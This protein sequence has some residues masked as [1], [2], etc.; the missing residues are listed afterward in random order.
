MDYII[1]NQQTLPAAEARLPTADRGFRFGDSLF[2]TIAVHGGK[3]CQIAWHLDRLARGLAA[4]KIR[5]DAAPLDNLCRSLI[6]KN[7]V[8]EGLLRIQISRGAGGRGYLPDP[9]AAPTVLIETAPMPD[10]PREPVA[11]WLSSYEKISPRALPVN[12]K[13]GQGNSTLA[14]I[15]AAE[16]HCADALLL[17]HAGHIAETSSGNIFWV[18]DSLL[19]TPKLSCGALDGSIRAALMRL[20]QVREVEGTIETLKNAEAVFITNA[21]WKTLPVGML[22][23]NGYAWD[24]AATAQRFHDIILSG[25]K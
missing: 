9:N 23:P 7:N 3:P 24:S 14:R 15:E 1:L 22:R 16:N 5:C 17:N 21:V 8:K 25:I 18:K 19:Y 11:L 6:E 20:T 10:I 12:F 4:L 2:E 13:L